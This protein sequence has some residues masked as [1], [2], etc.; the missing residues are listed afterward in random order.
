MN[1]LPVDC[2][3]TGAVL[4]PIARAAIARE[5]DLAAA[6]DESAPWLDEPH[7]S[8][9]TL[10]I[11]AELRGCIGS[12]E[13]KR[14]LLADLKSNAV[15]AAFRDP[16]FAPLTRREFAGTTIE[17]S[18]LSTPRLLPFAATEAGLIAQ[19]MPLRD[20]VLLEMGGLR[21]T[22]LPQVW[23][24]LPDPRDFLAEL[25]LKAGLPK[26]FWSP[27]LRVSL[28]QVQKWGENDLALAHS[29]GTRS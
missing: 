6:A 23:E 20:G 29:T 22:F 12:I 14:S 21:A 25:K 27:Q 15:G 8:F 19:L 7:A 11:D 4:L 26:N 16:R 13:A 5:L 28:Y 3:K 24:S 2:S 1:M 18:L 17:V 10:K 9:V